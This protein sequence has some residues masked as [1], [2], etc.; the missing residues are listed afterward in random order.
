MVGTAVQRTVPPDVRLVALRHAELPVED[1]AEV[2]GAV[3][4]ARPD[5]LINCA[6]YTTVDQAETERERAHLVN[7][8]G[9]AHLAA[10]ARRAGARLL[11]LS[12]DY[13]FDGR[14]QRPYREDDAP[15][16]LSMYGRTKLAGEQAVQTA[17]PEAHLIVRTQW[18]FGVGGPNFVATILRLARERPRLEV[19]NDQRGHP[20]YATDLATALWRLVACDARGVVHCANEGVASWFDVALAAVAAAGLATTIEPC[21]TS[22]MPRPAQRPEYSVLDC[23][24]YTALVGA[25][26]RPWKEPLAEYVALLR[27]STA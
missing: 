13:V 27:H 24:R 6:G 10:A 9:P 12:S 25:P 8:I 22:D 11:H 4:Q 21:S 17:L 14:A 3:A 16:P 5:W 19:V 1:S 23:T 2:N 15:A 7:A 18:L 20:T 26:L